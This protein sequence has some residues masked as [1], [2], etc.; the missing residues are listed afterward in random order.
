MIQII[1]IRFYLWFQRNL[2]EQKYNSVDKLMQSMK[3]PAGHTIE[4]HREIEEFSDTAIGGSS[5]DIY[6]TL[7]CAYFQLL[8]ASGT[9]NYMSHLRFTSKSD[10]HVSAS[11]SEDYGEINK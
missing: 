5:K 6:Y 2:R 4:D 11:Q 9:P 10:F 3:R 8:G 7:H 1:K